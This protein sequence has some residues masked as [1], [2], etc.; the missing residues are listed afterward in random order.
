MQVRKCGLSSALASE[1]LENINAI[2]ILQLGYTGADAATS[3]LHQAA[4][5]GRGS[6]TNGT[7]Q[8]ALGGC[9]KC[10]FSHQRVNSTSESLGTVVD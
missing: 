2:S 9:K 10:D 6:E 3:G 4:A 1:D 5:L 8:T 7:G